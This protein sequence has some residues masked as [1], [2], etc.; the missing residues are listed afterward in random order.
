MVQS[1]LDLSEDL[2]DD[3]LLDNELS[4]PENN[5]DLDSDNF[6]DSDP[7]NNNDNDADSS[8]NHILLGYEPLVDLAKVICQLSC[9]IGEYI[10][11]AED[12]V[13]GIIFP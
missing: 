4:F 2:G 12:S 11:N 5:D 10:K 8:H 6:D 3:L 13:T 7:S 1:D 9:T